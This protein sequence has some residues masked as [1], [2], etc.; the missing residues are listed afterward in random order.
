MATEIRYAD[1][2]E[3]CNLLPFYAFIPNNLV[4]E[5]IGVL[6]R[7]RKQRFSFSEMV[8]VDKAIH[9][10]IQEM[11]ASKMLVVSPEKGK[12]NGLQTPNNHARHRG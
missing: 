9:A 12:I 1:V 5:V 2:V 6:E 8:K 10:L 7:K 4:I 11:L 3:A